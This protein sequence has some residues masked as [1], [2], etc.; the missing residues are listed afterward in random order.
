MT[1]RDQA[2]IDPDTAPLPA[3]QRHPVLNLPAIALADCTVETL[4]ELHQEG[5]ERYRN[6]PTSPIEP[7]LSVIPTAQISNSGWLQ[8]KQALAWRLLQ[9]CNFCVHDCQVDRTAGAL[10]YCRLD[11]R[12]PLAG[13]YLHWGEEA[14][15]RPT[16]A[17]F[18]SGCTMHCLYCHNWRE[19]FHFKEIS[20]LDPQALAQTLAQ[21][22]TR[23]RTISLLGGTPEPHLHTILDLVLALDPA[24]RAPL[25]FNS[26]A[27][28][29]AS[30][31]ALMEGVIDIYLPDFKHGNQNCAWQLTKMPNYLETVTRNLE[32][33]RQQGAAMLVRHLALPGHLDCCSRPILETLAHEFKGI[34]V[35]LMT[36]Y[37]PLYKA[38]EKPGIDRPLN[39]AEK[40]TLHEWSRE[41][42]LRLIH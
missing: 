6:R 7:E 37:R 31:L 10:G 30:G 26:N 12:S 21:E 40:A 35:N 24:I 25:V 28:L 8:V 17:L 4:W 42:G 2:E 9:T 33:Y 11:S 15:I 16:W 27:T 18:L 41:L 3:R 29:S 1:V 5:L 38:Q 36:Q 39:E 34:A 22:R 19:T 20:A 32:A 13:S 23:Y 14:P